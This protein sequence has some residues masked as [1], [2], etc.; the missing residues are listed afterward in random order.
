VEEAAL[1]DFVKPNQTR[2]RLEQRGN[3]SRPWLNGPIVNGKSAGC[4]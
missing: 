3:P 2:L 4:T 1:E